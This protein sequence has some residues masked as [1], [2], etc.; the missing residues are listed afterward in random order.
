M[1]QH[2]VLRLSGPGG[3]ESRR[4]SPEEVSLVCRPTCLDLLRA[5]AREDPPS[6]RAAAR[7]VGRDVH[8]V[9]DNLRELDG[10]D[11]V[12]FER[13]GRSRRPVVPYEQLEVSVGL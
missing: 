10:L 9:H 7:L 1:T 12:E 13:D 8:Q 6:I 11:L 5:V 3:E 4:L 2:V